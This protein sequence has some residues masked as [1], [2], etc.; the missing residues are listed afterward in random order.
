[1]GVRGVD[2]ED[3]DSLILMACK[4]SLRGI[5]NEWLYKELS[6]IDDRVRAVEGELESMAVCPCCQHYS[7]SQNGEYEIC[8]VCFWEDDGSTKLHRYSDPNHMT[9]AEGQV[10]FA[11]FG[12]CSRTSTKHV[13]SM[14]ST[15]YRRSRRPSSEA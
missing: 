12:A 15:K 13:D 7:L 10:N 6:A 11:S 2:L 1:M 3:Y 9:L 5:K 4:A 8:P 14:G